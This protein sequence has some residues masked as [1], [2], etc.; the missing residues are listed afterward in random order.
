MRLCRTI[1]ISA[2]G[3]EATDFNQCKKSLPKTDPYQG[4]T[5]HPVLTACKAV[6]E[7]QGFR[8]LATEKPELPLPGCDLNKCGC[9]YQYHDDRREDEDRRVGLRG[10]FSDLNQRVGQNDRRLAGDVDRR[11]NTAWAETAAYY[12]NY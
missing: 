1:D 6:S 10:R 2:H 5:I 8:Y 12:N 9:R 11:R 3:S 7:Q 4:V